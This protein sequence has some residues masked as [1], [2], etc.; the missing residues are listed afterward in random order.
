[1]KIAIIGA[2]STGKTGIILNLRE[3]LHK[4]NK[5]F[6]ITEEKARFCPL[7]VDEKATIKTE[8]WIL[9]T[10]ISAEISATAGKKDT[11]LLCD[12]CVIDPLIYLRLNYK[13]KDIPRFIVDLVKYWAKTY[14]YIFK[15]QIDP[16]YENPVKDG[17]RNT[18]AEWQK[19]L[20][21]EYEKCL[22]ELKINYLILPIK[23][24]EKFILEAA[25]IR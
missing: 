6:L 19:V 25:K 15:T 22:E 10:Q 4:K 24:I 12:R 17:F 23:N 14:D 20:D 16:K 3:K 13:K 7:P 21:I 8:L 1:M 5:D 9:S 11:I 2:Q 18:N